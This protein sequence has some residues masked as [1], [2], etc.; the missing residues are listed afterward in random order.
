MKNLKTFEGFQSVKKDGKT[1]KEEFNKMS[2][3]DKRKVLV[4]EFGV[5][6]KEASEICVKDTK[7]K[8]LPKEIKDNF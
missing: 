7:V 1:T 8:D 4:N 6:K 5:D 2:L 3:S